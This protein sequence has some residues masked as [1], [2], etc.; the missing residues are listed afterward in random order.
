M[1]EQESYSV[2]E[3]AD[4]VGLHVSTVKKY[5]RNNEIEYTRTPGGTEEYHIPS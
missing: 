4:K 5:C 3:F 1:N 2:G